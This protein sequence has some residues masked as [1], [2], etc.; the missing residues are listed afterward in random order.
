[1]PWEITD[2]MDERKRFVLKALDPTAC[3]SDLCR[4]FGIARKTG[5][6]WVERFKQSG[7]K[8]LDDL[9][10]RPSSSP[11]KVPADLQLE[12]V[13]LRVRY[14]TWGPKKLQELLKRDSGHQRV[15]AASTIAKIL[16]EAGL[17]QPRRTRRPRADRSS[18]QRV[19]PQRPNDLWTVDFKGWWRT[20]DG[21][22]CEPLTI[23]D[24][25]SRFL[26]DVRAM[27]STRTELV[28]PVFEKAFSRYGLPAAI[29]TDNGP[30]FASTR[31]VA[32]L[33]RLSAWWVA[34]G[35]QLDTIDPG[36]P[37][38]NGGHERMHR[39]LAAEIERR[40]GR[41]APEQQAFLD[42]WRFVFN[43]E[44]PH[45][46]LGM[47][48]PAE[49]YVPSEYAYSGEKPEIVYPEHFVVRT[50]S[51]R[52]YVNFRCKRRFVSEA[53]VAWP[54]GLRYDGDEMRVFFAE[55]CL[56]V[57]DAEFSRPLSR[58]KECE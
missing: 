53:L 50:V 56:G 5:Y 11:L 19:T 23:R 54:L 36:S 16:A 57:T 14:P 43:A 28:R 31:A 39:D 37:L 17:V 9:S 41:D 1:M 58:P 35:I 6:K 10:R 27:E 46:A 24:D 22:R 25:H 18:S 33:T 40:P 52:G 29:R 55:I 21:K 8:G 34:L 51:S 15:P 30:P 4:E 26:I 48:T 44:R 7:E 13:K 38:Q 47:K 32:R 12:I 3:M 20:E 49:L 2:V 42:D 45:E